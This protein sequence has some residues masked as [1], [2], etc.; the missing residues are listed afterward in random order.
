MT[1]PRSA[2]IGR[3]EAAAVAPFAS[4]ISPALSDP[5]APATVRPGG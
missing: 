1:T 2:R 5:A 4:H 3:G